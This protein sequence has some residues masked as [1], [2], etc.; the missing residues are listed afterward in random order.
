MKTGR[1][2]IAF[3]ILSI[4]LFVLLTISLFHDCLPA[5]LS[6]QLNELEHLTIMEIRIPRVL[7]AILS[8]MALSVSGMQMQSIFRNPL[9]GPYV[10]GIS[11]GGALGV[12]LVT[13]GVAYTGIGFSGTGA[14][15]TVVIASAIGCLVFLMLVF[16]IHL[17]LRH[18][19]TVLVAGILLGSAASAIVEILQY[20]SPE[21][22][23]KSFVVWTMGSLSSVDNTQIW[24]FLIFVSAGMILSLFL[25]NVLNVLRAGDDYAQVMGIRVNIARILV[26][27]STGILT[28]SVVAFCG[29][30]AF[31][32]I[33]VPH[34]TRMILKSYNHRLLFPGNILTGGI[35]L[36]I[37]D[38]A[39][40]FSVS[41]IQL[42][43]NAMTSLI[44]I[45]VI[46]YLILSKNKILLS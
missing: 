2:S 41:G 19:S 25:N 22:S 44:G 3:I 12:S 29:P 31:V 36:L 18:P 10:L 13:M 14:F 21:R 38:M 1:L 20:L 34:I 17:K 42:P 40:R 46:L 9:A 30:I 15:S 7:A 39:S 32:G 27:T 6:G 28:G 26:F 5:F 23:V 45:P 4:L 37:A 24:L 11:S 16:A 33:A 43:V 35:V 8:G